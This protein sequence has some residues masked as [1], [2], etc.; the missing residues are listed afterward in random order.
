MKTVN[1]FY[2]MFFYILCAISFISAINAFGH[3]FPDDLTAKANWTGFF[4]SGV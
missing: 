4:W 1:K 2:E 3:I